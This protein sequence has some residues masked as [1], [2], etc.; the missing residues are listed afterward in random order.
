MFNL[1][2]IEMRLQVGASKPLLAQSRKQ[3]RLGGRDA[4]CAG[5]SSQCKNMEPGQLLPQDLPRRRPGVPGNTGAL[6]SLAFERGSGGG[7]NG[8]RH[9]APR[10]APRGE[11]HDK[12]GW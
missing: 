9:T 12:V 1:E 5:D 11:I 3:V 6:G 2:A 4:P 10:Q 7:S 8:V